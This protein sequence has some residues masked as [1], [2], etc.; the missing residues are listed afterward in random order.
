MTFKGKLINCFWIRAN[1]LN[2]IWSR[3]QSIYAK[4]NLKE[5]KKGRI[6]KHLKN[7]PKTDLSLTGLV[8]RLSTI[9]TM[10]DQIN[11]IYY[12]MKWYLKLKSK[13]HKISFDIWWPPTYV[14]RIRTKTKKWANR[15]KLSP[16][17]V[18]HFF[19]FLFIHLF[20]KI[21]SL[22]CS[23]VLTSTEP[24]F[25]SSDFSSRLWFRFLEEA[26]SVTVMSTLPPS[27]FNPFCVSFLSDLNFGE[28]KN[29]YVH[30]H[31]Q[32]IENLSNYE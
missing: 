29:S 30:K 4:P 28:K 6:H 7:L 18:Y 12:W 24:S 13:N 26:V 25:N 17:F 27:S 2:R 16:I 9:Y 10:D 22:G 8:V 11:N 20:I 21:L 32:K 19:K 3:R 5:E 14:T 23:N 1:L 15:K 31:K